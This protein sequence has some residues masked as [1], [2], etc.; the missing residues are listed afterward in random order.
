MAERIVASGARPANNLHRKWKKRVAALEEAGLAVVAG[1]GGT[2][3]QFGHLLSETYGRLCD[4]ILTPAPDLAAFRAKLEC[5][6]E[7]VFAHEP[8]LNRLGT[9]LLADIRRLG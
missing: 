1:A 5:C 9:A 8:V 6:Q 3:D 4:L 2:P 7:W